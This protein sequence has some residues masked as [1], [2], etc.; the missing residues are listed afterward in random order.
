MKNRKCPNRNHCWGYTNNSCDDCA[1]GN[2]IN[3]LHRKIDKLKTENE[4]L[5]AENVRLNRIAYPD[6]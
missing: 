2:C 6:F 1:I 4:K 3:K 5:K